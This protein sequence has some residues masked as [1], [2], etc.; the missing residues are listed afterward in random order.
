MT[1]TKTPVSITRLEN[2]KKIISDTGNQLRDPKGWYILINTRAN[3]AVYTINRIKFSFSL[4]YSG[5]F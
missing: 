3:K 5:I 2:T 4:R 1:T